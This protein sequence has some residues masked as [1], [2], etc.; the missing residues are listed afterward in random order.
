MKFSPLMPLL[1]LTISCATTNSKVDSITVGSA[2]AAPSTSTKTAL[3]P[4]A[5]K[6][7]PIQPRGLDFGATIKTVA[8]GSST[9]QDLPQPLWS[10]I[11]VQKPDLFLFMGDA[12]QTLKPE[13]Q[14]VA[15]QYRKLNRIPEFRAMREKIPFLVTWNDLD[16]G[17]EL[18]GADFAGKETSKKEFLRNWTYV[19]DSIS[20]GQGGIYHAKII[21][22]KKK[23]VQFIMLDTRSFRSPLTK[24]KDATKGSF[25]ITPNIDAKATILGE[26]Q[27][28]WLE[29]QL[30]RPA[31]L[32]F[33]VTSIP[34]IAS[35]IGSEK[36]SNFPKERQR[37]FDLIKKTHVRNVVVLSGDRRQASI[38]KTA[39]KD[40]GMLF[41][42]TASPINEPAGIA[43]KDAS[44]EGDAFAV[45]NFGLANID[46]AAQ[47]LNLQ[48][49][50][51]D[52]KTLNSV[53]YKLQ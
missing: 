2:P 29:A 5:K 34:L 30:K 8:F 35:D 51:K 53:T 3:T 42:I 26:E 7:S 9:N 17:Q 40:W 25:K 47:K 27:W 24:E 39:L 37:F 46:W 31:Q 1:L 14:P 23:M 38:A 11:L 18:G 20:M 15:E 41:D 6:E 10:T 13:Q 52:N 50:D 45:E 36:W 43:E 48:L 4:E 19:R 33:I 16:Y 44:F 32:R 28:E 22:P 49:K 21:G 12:V